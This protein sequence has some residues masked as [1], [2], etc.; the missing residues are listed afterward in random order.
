M[1]DRAYDKTAVLQ[2]IVPAKNEIS[3]S[4]NKA[5]QTS[6]QGVAIGYNT[7]L[8]TGEAPTGHWIA[9]PGMNRSINIYS[10]ENNLTIT[11]SGMLQLNNT[12]AGT[13][14]QS[15]SYAI[16][17]FVDD[18]LYSVRTFVITG[19]N[20]MTFLSQS[21]DIKANFDNLP[22]GNHAFSIYVRTRSNL[23]GNATELTWVGSAAGCSNINNDMAKGNLSVQSQQF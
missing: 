19:R 8:G 16:G 5:T 7:G 13:N 23:A 17:L 15:H 20:G 12:T 3:T 9:L 18:H 1:W 10:A 21:W 2:L 11:A 22:P 14:N 4:T 6:G